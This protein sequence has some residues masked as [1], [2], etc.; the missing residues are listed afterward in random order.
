[1]VGERQSRTHSL[2]CHRATQQSAGNIVERTGEGIADAPA[3]PSD[4]CDDALHLDAWA[5]RAAGG[6]TCAEGISRRE[7]SARFEDG[8]I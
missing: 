3:R 2:S 1:M 8:N 4:G 6:V 7:H 5:F